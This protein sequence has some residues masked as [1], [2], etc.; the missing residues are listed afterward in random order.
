MSGIEIAEV[1]LTTRETP[2]IEIADKALVGVY[3][4][5]VSGELWDSANLRLQGSFD[6]GADEFDLRVWNGNILDFQPDS[7]LLSGD[8]MGVQE[9][10]TAGV[11]HIRA[12]SV[13]TSGGTF[14]DQTYAHTIRFALKTPIR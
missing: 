12:I 9:Y 4:V 3:K 10:C 5:F 6:G 7:Q 14:V 8:Y 13:A 2:W 1:T 11:R